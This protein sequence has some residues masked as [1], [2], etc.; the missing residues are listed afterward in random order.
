MAA[1]PP[2]KT[3]IASPPAA[4][5]RCIGRPALADFISDEI[6]NDHA[7]P[8]AVLMVSLLRPRQFESITRV[9]AWDSKLKQIDAR[10]ARV[11][12]ATDRFTRLSDE[13]LC[14]VLPFLATGAQAML[15]AARIS[16]VLQDAGA[17]E[18]NNIAVRSSVGIAIWPEHGVDADDL[19]R[20]ADMAAHIAAESGEEFHTIRPEDR[21]DL[22][23]LDTDTEGQLVQA[24]RQNE[25][26]VFYQPQ[27]D[28]ATRRCIGAEALLRWNLNDTASVSTAM[29]I[30]I[31]EQTGLIGPLTYSVINTSL[32][33]ADRLRKE[34]I[35]LTLS[36][37]MSTKMLTDLEVPDIVQQAIETWDVA[38][39]SLTFEI[40]E[41]V[42]IGDIERSLVVLTRLR[43]MGI[44]LSIDDFGTGYS[45]LAYM[46]RFPVQELKIDKSFVA[47]ML[48]SHGDRQIVQSV[49]DL[50]HNFALQVVAE[51]VEDEATF[52]E[53]KSMGCDTAQG[54]LFSP[55]LSYHEFVKWVQARN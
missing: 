41:G 31:A 18:M 38:P 42:M 24:I 13:K 4:D 22:Q 54:F 37:N 16:A 50:S 29:A 10:I 5:S 20:S 52:A 46:K 19:V 43:D 1:A 36:V 7:K 49:I 11:L 23:R 40:T 39:D 35:E 26:I 2:L 14:I 53:L 8:L 3:Y 48:S 44:R 51:G 47:N 33:D 34:G 30:S 25:L 27:I 32:R 21:S 17:G 15:A 12:R 45:S 6:R 55:A 28:I 9:S